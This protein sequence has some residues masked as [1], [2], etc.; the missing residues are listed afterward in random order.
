MRQSNVFSLTLCALFAALIAAG[1]F[2]RVPIPVV[3]FTL[4]FLF[5]ALAGLLLGGRLGLYSVLLYL[6]MGLIGLPVFAEGGGLFYVLKPSFGYLIGFA[7]AAYWIGRVA[8]RV[9][10]PSFR[11][12][13]LASFLGL[14]IVYLFGMVYYALIS[15]F[16]LGNPI[17]LW[18]LFLYCFL[19]AV[20]G[21]IVLCV[22]AAALATRLIPHLNLNRK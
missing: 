11:R 17:G 7:V 1:A 6:F 3:P 18:P 9:P 8:H 15:S 19:L 20:P 2:L 21:D 5:A 4:Q 12:L 22:L 14:A 10:S 13:L 16:Y